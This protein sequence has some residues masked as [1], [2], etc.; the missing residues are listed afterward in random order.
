M[1][2]IYIET[3]IVSHA[4]ARPSSDPNIAALQTQARDWW[5]IERP[6]FDLMTS[7]LVLDE[8]SEGDTDAVAERLRIL[9]GVR[10]VAI[11]DEVRQ[12]ARALI[13]PSM[14]P[15]KAGSRRIARCRCRR[16][17]D[18]ISIDA[19]LPSHRKC[20]H[21]STSLYRA[22]AARL[23]RIASLHASRVSWRYIR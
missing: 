1:P 23:R 6:R 21:A 19:E 14:M 11:T 3:S 7:Q 20:A 16:G 2:T 5:R 4:T 13:S 10:L 9:A 22:R 17:K 18:R 8:A 15:P 12:L